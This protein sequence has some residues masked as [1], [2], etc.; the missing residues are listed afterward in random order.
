VAGYTIFY[1]CGDNSVPYYVRGTN[2]S[3]VYFDGASLW[4]YRV[5]HYSDDPAGYALDASFLVYWGSECPTHTI[6]YRCHDRAGP[7]YVNNISFGGYGGVW[8][9]TD[10]QYYSVSHV[11]THAEGSPLSASGLSY[12]GSDCPY[13]IFYRCVD[14]AGPYWVSVTL[15][16]GVYYYS[17]DGQYYRVDHYSNDAEGSWLNRSHLSYYGSDCP[18][19]PSFNPAW[20]LYA[21]SYVGIGH[22]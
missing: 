6:F 17:W 13:T 14:N 10:G 8:L 22:V 16:P 21:N 3:G 9:Y 12:Y 11:S 2:Y 19:S 18:G 4:W 5:D 15:P 20:A 7:Y 1:P